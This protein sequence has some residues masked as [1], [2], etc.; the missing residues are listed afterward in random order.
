MP[1]R[2][3]VA[4]LLLTLGVLFNSLIAAPKLIVVISIDQFRYDYL[5]RFGDYYGSGGFH[6]LLQNGASFSNATYKHAF[7]ITAPGHAV[8]LTGAYGDR[9]GIATN[10]WYDPRTNQKVYCVSDSTV[11]IIGAKGAGRSPA[12][13]IVPTFGDELR[14]HTGFKSKVISISQKDRAAI[15]LGG[16]MANGVFWL[17]DSSFVT[18]T[19]YM[20]SLPSWVEK[21]NA[22]GVVNSY[23]GKTWETVLPDNAHATMDID[24]ASYEVS[25]STFGRSFPHPIRGDSETHLT[26]SYYRA[27][28]TSPF[29]VDFLAQFAKAAIEGEHL[30]E[31]PSPDL[32]CVSFSSIDY[33]GHDF[34]PHSREILEMAVQTDRILGDFLRYLD[35]RIGLKNTLVVLTSDHGVTPIPEYIRSRHPTAD[36]GRLSHARLHE[37]CNAALAHSFGAPTGKQSWIKQ[38][39]DGNIYLDPDV[40]RAKNL[41]PDKVATA[42]ADSLMNLHEIALALPRQTILSCSSTSGLE[43]KMKRSFHPKR[44]GDVLFVL[45]PFFYIDDGSEGAE[46]GNPYEHDAHVPLILMG[47]GIR[48]GTY[49]TEASPA[50]IGPTLSALLG[51][52]FPAGCEGRVL[53]EA[54][55]LR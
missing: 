47:E 41:D 19:C 28:L 38:L 22:S 8:I 29:G 16:K 40:I 6:Y 39:M 46:H 26:Q 35:A 53:V 54:L 24:D 11:S 44:S 42:L 33:V 30:G 48:A 20:T 45:K 34:G 9:N 31:S 21:F 27:V 1:V 32:L 49:A 25:F 23:F 2:R 5:T 18:S 14:L 13:L 37:C 7:N 12:N 17:I 10:S 43:A 51:V 15:L 55:L 3:F 52:E 4:P 50:D 36:V